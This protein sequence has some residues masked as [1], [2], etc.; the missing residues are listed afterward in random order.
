MKKRRIFRKVLAGLVLASGFLALIG[1]VIMQ[2]W[3]WS[4]A[5]VFGVGTLGFGQAVGLFV[6]SRILLWGVF[7]PWGRRRGFSWQGE[8]KQ[9]WMNLT[10]EEQSKFRERFQGKCNYHSFQTKPNVSE[11]AIDLSKNA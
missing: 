7:R 4:V 9:K 8:W 10:P 1:L 2:L 3:N 5:P 11:A 6:L